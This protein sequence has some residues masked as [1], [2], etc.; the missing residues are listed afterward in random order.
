ML[1]NKYINLENFFFSFF[2]KRIQSKD[3]ASVQCINILDLLKYGQVINN[4]YI[5]TSQLVWCIGPNPCFQSKK[6][7]RRYLLL[8]K[9]KRVGGKE[10]NKFIY[11]IWAPHQ[12]DFSKP[13]SR[14]SNF[15]KVPRLSQFPLDLCVKKEEKL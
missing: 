7:S 2:K 9:N 12:I 15:P 3:T 13:R 10:K 14:G 11:F 8:A 5:F 4:C 6:V 1:Y